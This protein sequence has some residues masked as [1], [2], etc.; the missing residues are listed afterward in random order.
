MLRGPMRLALVLLAAIF[1]QSGVASA[2]GP[3]AVG[4]L[5]PLVFPETGLRVVAKLDTGAKTSV[6][7]AEDVSEFQRD[8]E[9]WV[10]FGLRKK[11][12][13]GSAHV[14]EARVVGERKVR[15][16]VGVATRKLV[17]L[18]VCV[19][20]ERRRILFALGRRDAM[21]YR[22]ILGRRALEGRLLV[23]AERKFTS[24][25]GCTP[26]GAAGGDP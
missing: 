23:D 13:Q 26:P 25:P 14:F 11:R 18:W 15:A 12:G 21:N 16:A 1:V 3:K 22:V 20:G 9:P 24:E 17:D 10:R 8:G 19:A 4:W 7:D 5:E 2:S 6:L